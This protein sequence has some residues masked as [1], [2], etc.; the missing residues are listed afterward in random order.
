MGNDIIKNRENHKIAIIITGY[1]DL[2]FMKNLDEALEVL[3]GQGFETF[4]VSPE[5]PKNRHDHYLKS[6]VPKLNELLDGLKKEMGE[7]DE[8]VLFITGH[9]TVVN[10]DATVCFK[11][12][13][14]RIT[15]ETSYMKKLD[16]LPYKMRT[17]ILAPCYSGNAN[18]LFL[19]KERTALITS[20]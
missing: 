12:D 4:V 17:V 1:A 7:A 16:E 11:D 6:D 13:E 19:K 3:G 10:E 9:G 20:E 14:D 15:C 5:E 2:H 8:V 18:N